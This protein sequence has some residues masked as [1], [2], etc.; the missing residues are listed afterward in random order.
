MAAGVSTQMHSEVLRDL[1]ERHRGAA[2]AE[3]GG[4]LDEFVTIGKC[5][6]KHV[7]RLLKQAEEVRNGVA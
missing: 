3:Q 2:R 6:R 7:G 1:R 4:T 5:H